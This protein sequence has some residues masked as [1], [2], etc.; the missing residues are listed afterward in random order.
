VSQE[1]PDPECP[2]CHGSGKVW[3]E[4][5]IGA[6]FAVLCRFAAAV[7]QNSDDHA[8]SFD[9]RPFQIEILEA[10][11]DTLTGEDV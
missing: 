5:L 10:I 4:E 3:N 1:L 2:V 6:T 8:E 11:V 7:I 9:Y